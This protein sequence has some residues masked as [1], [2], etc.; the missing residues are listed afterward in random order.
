LENLV[1][2]ASALRLFLVGAMWRTVGWRWC[3][4]IL[5]KAFASDDE[6]FRNL[7]GIFLVQAGL[8]TLPLLREE[9]ENH[10]NIPL[11]LMLIADIGDST[12]ESLII[13][14]LNYDDPKVAEAARQA[15]RTLQVTSRL[16]D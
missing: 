8:R 5:L 11:I 7:S 16:M 15:I 6:D 12:S 9:L 10:R 4:K 1:R 14:Y 13:P 2:I 3:G